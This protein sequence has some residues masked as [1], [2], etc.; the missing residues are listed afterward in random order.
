MS[1]QCSLTTM[2]VWMNG[3]DGVGVGDGV[4]GGGAILYESRAS[5]VH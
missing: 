2:S 4:G 5:D 3:Q 1:V